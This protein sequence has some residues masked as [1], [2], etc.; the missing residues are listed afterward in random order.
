MLSEDEIID[1][2]LFGTPKSWQREMDRQ[3]FDP[4]ASSPSEVLAFMERIDISSEHFD[5]N[6]K[7]AKVTQG[8]GKK[9][10]SYNKGNSDADGSKHCMLHGN[11]NTHDALECKTLMAQ[12]KKLKSNNGAN[13]KGKGGGSKS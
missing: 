11:N 6:K 1:I 3:G 2:L 10:S 5:G 12:A 4:L 8:K 7:V 13:K 9:K